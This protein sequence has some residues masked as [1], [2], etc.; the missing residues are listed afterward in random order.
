MQSLHTT[1][2]YKL[3]GNMIKSFVVSDIWN[4]G[5]AIFVLGLGVK[6]LIPR[7]TQ[8]ESSNVTHVFPIC[9]VGP[10]RPV[11]LVSHPLCPVCDFSTLRFVKCVSK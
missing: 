3:P 6:L 4:L 11:R 10:V 8:V 1:L 9:P 5:K 7:T 2:S